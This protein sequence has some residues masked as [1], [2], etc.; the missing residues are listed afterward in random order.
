MINKYNTGID[1]SGNMNSGNMNSGDYNSG[2]WNSGNMNSGDC[3][4]GNNNSGHLNS[5]NMNSGNLNS[6][7]FNTNFPDKIRIFNTW[8]D[9]THEEFNKKYNI[10]ADIPLNRWVDK[11]DMTEE[12][13][14]DVSGW[15]Q[16]G[17]YL[18]T[19]DFKE[20]CRVWWSEN[21]HRHSDFLNLPNFNADIFKEITGIDVDE[22][23]EELTMEEVC[24]ELGRTIKIKK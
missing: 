7:H 4:S 6:G 8:V 17:G 5:G 10:Y 16:M 3:N 20:A 11:A 18:K 9:M 22:K 1:N 24:K 21:P 12:E 15:E 19:L 23:V 13:K 14:K 2:H